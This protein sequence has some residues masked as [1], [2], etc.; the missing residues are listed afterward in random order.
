MNQS[1]SQK[2]FGWNS[3]PNAAKGVEHRSYKC[4]ELQR[5]Q[6]AWVRDEVRESGQIFLHL[7]YFGLYPIDNKEQVKG[8]KQK[9][10]YASCNL[11]G[12][13]QQLCGG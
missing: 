11:N 9:T 6:S 1:L 4:S 2:G 10:I 12:C 7:K 5:K 8:C 3:R 13:F